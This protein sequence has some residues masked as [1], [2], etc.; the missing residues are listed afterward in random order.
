MHLIAKF[1]STCEMCDVCPELNTR[2][3]THAP[4][5]CA[6]R[7]ADKFRSYYQITHL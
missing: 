3:S 6:A 5:S 4:K 1:S 2:N 7:C